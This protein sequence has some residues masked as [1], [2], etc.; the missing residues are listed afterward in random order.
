MKRCT[1]ARGKS[2]AC[3]VG[4]SPALFGILGCAEASEAA[5]RERR[6]TGDG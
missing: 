4:C 3:P 1:P 2:A 5:H 6:N